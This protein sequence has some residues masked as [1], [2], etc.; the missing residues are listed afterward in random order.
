MC[1]LL[2]VIVPFRISA[3]IPRLCSRIDVFP[4]QSHVI[5]HSHLPLL[6]INQLQ[7]N[8]PICYDTTRM[9]PEPT[10]TLTLP[11]IS[12][13]LTLDCR[14]YHPFSLSAS[15]KAPAWLKHAA[16][17][18]HPYAPMGGCYDDPVVGAVAAQLLRKGFL[19]GTFNF[20]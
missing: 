20:R 4:P 2:P 12:D 16:V 8:S 13:G 19:V 1:A 18:A 5:H 11:S 7:F 3:E 9:L 17:V 6:H 14:I 10:L 15:S